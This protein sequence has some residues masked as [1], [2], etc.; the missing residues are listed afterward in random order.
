MTPSTHRPSP[1]SIL[2]TKR[3]VIECLESEIAGVRDCY[4]EYPDGVELDGVI[5]DP[6]ALHTIRC[7]EV[8]LLLVRSKFPRVRRGR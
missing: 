4:Q 3:E 2:P 5:R 8:A 7:L 6:E 1:H